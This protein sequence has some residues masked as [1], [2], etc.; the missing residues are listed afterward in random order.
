MYD[1]SKYTIYRNIRCIEIY[2]VSKCTIY[3]NN[4]IYRKLDISIVSELSI[5]VGILYVTAR[6]NDISKCK[7]CRKLDIFGYIG[8][9][10]PAVLSD[11][12]TVL[13]GSAERYVEIYDISKA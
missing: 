6:Q 12:G 2:H 13:Y 11:R 7:I 4:K 3:R 8:T 10:T 5:R 9:S 1:V